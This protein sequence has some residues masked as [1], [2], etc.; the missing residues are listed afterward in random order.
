MEREG[1][2]EGR[3]EERG[4]KEVNEKGMGRRS[5]EMESNRELERMKKGRTEE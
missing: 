5:E 3:K 4:C 2:K 1:L